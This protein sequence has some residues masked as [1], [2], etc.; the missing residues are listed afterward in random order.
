ML[1]RLLLG[2]FFYLG[3]TELHA[4]DIEVIV[5]AE[6]AL[7]PVHISSAIDTQ[8]PQLQK[9]LH[10]LTEIFSND[11][12]LGDCL[13]PKMVK[14]NQAFPGLGLSL[15]L[16]YPNLTIMLLQQSK[17]PRTLC[18]LCLSQNLASDRQHI[19]QVADKVHHMLTG[20][21]GISAGKIVFSLSKSSFN[22]ELKQGELW[23][24]D[25]DG[26]NLHPVSSEDSLSITPKWLDISTSS[27]YFY[28]SYKYGIPKI[29]LGS[30]ENT[31]GKK[32]LSMKGNQFMPTFSA[33]K[34]LLAFVADTHGNPDLFL[35]S[36]SPSLG[37][38]GYP[39]RLLNETFGTQGN[40]TFNPEGS[41]LVFVSNKDGRPRL[42]IM[43]LSP[44]PQTP[45][46]L[47]KKYRNSS[48]PAWSPDGKKIAFCSVIHGVRQ[49]C[50]Y[51]LSSGEDYQLTTSSM[52]KEN[53]S[54]AIDSRHLI[55]SAGHPEESELYLLSL[56][57]KKTRK[58]VIG[59]GEKR[60]PSWGAFS[61]QSTK[62]M[63]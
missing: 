33:K 50:I 60:F 24:I 20:I 19:H 47:T 18:S 22:Q 29:F 23:T 40:P 12:A 3:I 11:L 7:I 5:R 17:T 57:T 21:P 14:I 63:L 42:Y 31:E 34:K 55:F 27:S 62:R 59:V 10:T 35:Q 28:V 30:L 43:S 56:V 15:Q 54:W 52:N 16:S 58:I 8:D 26:A 32:V 46:L 4:R 49:I 41:K 48:C 45:R 25:Y 37:P 44:E 9:Y 51:D 53:P 2:A 36:F 13:Q 6:H 38:L 39:Q 1:R 61:L